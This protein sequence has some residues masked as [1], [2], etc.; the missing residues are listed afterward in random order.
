MAS[1][2]LVSCFLVL[3]PK[4]SVYNNSN[5]YNKLF[6]CVTNSNIKSRYGNWYG[7]A[8]NVNCL[9]WY[10]R[11]QIVRNIQGNELYWV[12]GKEGPHHRYN[13]IIHVQNLADESSTK[14]KWTKHQEG[15]GNRHTSLY[16]TKTR[17]KKKPTHTH[18]HVSA[19]SYE[20]Q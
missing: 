5:H 16:T 6:S 7:Y 13:V 8:L 10:T 17:F 9:Y 18:T 20:H 19:I 11:V 12:V 15:S 3:D 2:I 14:I 4:N 1:E